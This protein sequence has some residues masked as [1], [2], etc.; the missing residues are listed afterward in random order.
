MKKDIA[1]KTPV[2][3]IVVEYEGTTYTWDRDTQKVEISKVE[4]VST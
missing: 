4:C 2:Y 1:V 3:E